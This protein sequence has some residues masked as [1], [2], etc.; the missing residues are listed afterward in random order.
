MKTLLGTA[1]AAVL[2]LFALAAAAGPEYVGSG[3]CKAC[4]L[5]QYKSWE[6]TKMGNSYWVLKNEA[7][8]GKANADREAAGKKKVVEDPAALS[9]RKKSAGLDPAKDY[10][11]SADCL[12]CHTVGYGKPGGFKS[13][14]ETP[15]HLGGGC[16]MCHGPGSA[17]VEV[18]RANREYKKAEVVS[19]GIHSPPGEEQCKV[20]HNPKSPFMKEGDTFNFA[21]R[22]AKGTHEHFPLANP[23]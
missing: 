10:S 8:I 7:G 20:C 23:H 12:P 19:A 17:Y 22:K 6:T 15:D 16:E 2:A 4:H 13:E 11:A 5:K 21:E 1:A 3:K 14:A 9:A 18:M